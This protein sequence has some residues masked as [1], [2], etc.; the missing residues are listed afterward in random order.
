MAQSWTFLRSANCHVAISWCS[1]QNSGCVAR[2]GESFVR[3]YAKDRQK[4]WKRGKFKVSNR[5]WDKFHGYIIQR[6]NVGGQC[7]CRR[8][9]V[10]RISVPGARGFP[11]PSASKM[12]RGKRR[13]GV[14]FLNLAGKTDRNRWKVQCSGLCVT[15]VAFRLAEDRME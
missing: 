2:V 6:E 1:S 13:E 8:K 11:P 7:G 15:L 14:S 5:Q 10:W 3:G 12:Y 4:S 9:S